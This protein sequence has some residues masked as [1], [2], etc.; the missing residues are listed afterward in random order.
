MTRI[1]Y[2]NGRYQPHGE[3]LVHIE[4]R[5]YQFA[6]GIYEVTAIINGR[7]I[8][9][10][11]HLDRLEHSLATLRISM[12]MS[13][14]A[15]KHVTREVLRRNGLQ[16]GII[17]IQ[18]TRGV[19]HRDHPFPNPAQ[20]SSLVMTAKPIDFDLI[21]NR[22]A[23]GIAVIT[24]P[25]IRWGRCDVKSIS[26][27]PNVLAKQAARESGAFEAW[28]IDDKGYVTEGSS[29]NAW[30]VDK[31]GQL[32]TRQ[33]SH[34]I[35]GGI[36]R[37]ILL[38]EAKAMKLEVIERP[39]SLEE[40]LSA[41]EAFITSTTSFLLPVIKINEHQIGEGKP[42]PFSRRLRAQYMEHAGLK[43]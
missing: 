29:T 12:P 21:A 30:I 14:S 35:L 17:Y 11:P 20:K 7:L 2:V 27:L 4:D 9:E 36:T 28:L 24:Q 8:D 43:G 34:A 41:Q 40:A 15:L 25:D 13:R 37:Q 23:H 18:I 1:A 22:A 16:N 10:E 39:F 19:A 32:I 31:L 26:L 42:G 6:D 3:A 33:L 5:G 38:Q